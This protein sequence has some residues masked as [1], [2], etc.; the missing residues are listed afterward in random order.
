M[1]L[2]HGSKG[3]IY[4]VH[5]FKPK[6]NEHALLD[7]LEMLAGVT[8]LNKQIHLFAPLLNSPSLTNIASVQPSQKD[9]PI[10][11]MVKRRGNVTYIFAVGMRNTPVTGTFTL[12]SV[13]PKP[14]VEVVGEGRELM[15]K[16][17]RFVDDFQPYG[18][19]IYRVTP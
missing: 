9:T 10:D 18:V 7:D 1:S 2:V 11:I 3:I 19:H 17:N 16:N 8:A 12:T 15:L 6:F 5:Q 4:F 14:K 13:S